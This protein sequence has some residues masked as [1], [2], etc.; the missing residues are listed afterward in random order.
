MYYTEKLYNYGSYTKS[1]PPKSDCWVVVARDSVHRTEMIEYT[2]DRW[3][4][5]RIPHR[6][7]NDGTLVIQY[8]D[9]FRPAHSPKYKS[10]R[11]IQRLFNGLDAS[12]LKELRYA[13]RRLK[14]L[15]GLGPITLKSQAEH[16]YWIDTISR[17]VFGHASVEDECGD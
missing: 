11:R 7:M 1:N 2:R 15:G 5:T 4:S 3:Y 12:A 13:Q 17:I 9:I 10:T 14:N 6:L 16:D 8:G